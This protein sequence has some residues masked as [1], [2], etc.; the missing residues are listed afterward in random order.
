MSAESLLL[1]K[2]IET[3]DFSAIRDSGITNEYFADPEA[4][5]A[6][7]FITDHYSQYGQLPN[8]DT[9]ERM[10]QVDLRLGA[11]EPAKFY[12]DLVIR[13]KRLT[14]LS[15]GVQRG[16][17]G[18]K[19]QDPEK[20]VEA[21]KEAI[22]AAS[23][24][25]V[26]PETGLMDLRENI[27][28]RWDHYQEL[29]KHGNAIDGIPYPWPAFNRTTMGIH[30]G[31]FISVVARMKTGKSWLE[32]A[33]ASHFVQ[34]GYSFLIVTMEMPIKE[35]AQRYDSM[36][37]KLP[38]GDFRRG[39]LSS[40]LESRYSDVLQTMSEAETPL[41]I[42]G[43][44]VV[45]TPMDLGLLIEELKPDVVLVDGLYFMRVDGAQAGMKKY[46]RVSMVVDELQSLALQKNIPIIGTTQFNRSVRKGKLDAEA[47]D[48]GFAY[49]IG[50]NSTM[51]V[52]MFQDNDMRVAKR[53]L[54]RILEYRHGEPI[55]LLVNWDF[56]TMDFSELKVTS[57]EE[58][59]K[60]GEEER[61]AF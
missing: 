42:A 16:I 26:N 14:T 15:E 21:L 23:R 6:Y 35:M 32:I 44:S 27:Q 49:E 50:Q 5:Q 47:G 51:L 34:N 45:R 39:K 54:I 7:L 22:A 40:E 3:E 18:I 11:P 56:D 24:E 28:E 53:M 29:K 58:L 57:V 48:V 38:F 55:D 17:E 37:A 43:N 10:T 1:A 12:A 46:E 20:C 33:L 36:F 59:Q 25:E 4:L 8:V 52:G 9:I 60:E 61:I 41:W 30:P 13:K 31:D 19:G 2:V